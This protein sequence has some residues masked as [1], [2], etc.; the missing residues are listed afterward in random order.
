MTVSSRPAWAKFETKTNKQATLKVSLALVGKIWEPA[1][2]QGR[3][4][5]DFYY[6]TV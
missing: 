2:L 4:Q 1:S 5:L 3:C 6:H